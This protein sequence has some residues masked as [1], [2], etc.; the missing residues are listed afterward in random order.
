M[1]QQPLEQI[2]K[3]NKVVY[4]VIILAQLFVQMARVEETSVL[5]YMEGSA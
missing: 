3:H 5:A 2:V 1:K 4:L